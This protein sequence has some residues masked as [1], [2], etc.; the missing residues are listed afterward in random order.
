[1]KILDKLFRRR[2]APNDPQHIVQKICGR[3][4]KVTVYRGTIELNDVEKIAAV[5]EELFHNERI[6]FNAR[7]MA[8]ARETAKRLHYGGVS[9]R[10]NPNFTLLEYELFL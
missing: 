5:F 4:Y 2:K 3:K 9:L 7:C 8:I 10:S 6:S 1:M